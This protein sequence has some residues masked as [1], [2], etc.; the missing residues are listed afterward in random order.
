MIWYLEV[1]HLQRRQCCP[2]C[3]PPLSVEVHSILPFRVDCF[4]KV[5][6]VT[7]KPLA[8]LKVVCFLRI[9]LKIYQ[10]YP[11]T[12]FWLFDWLIL[13]C[14][15]YDH[16][17]SFFICINDFGQRPSVIWNSMNSEVYNFKTFSANHFMTKF[18]MFAFSSF[19]Q[20]MF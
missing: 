12:F 10:A 14:L 3:L 19:G 9:W 11:Y 5:A 16:I 13:I 2:K 1:P 15:E 17:H 20:G 7:W 6:C 4:S 8:V 18:W